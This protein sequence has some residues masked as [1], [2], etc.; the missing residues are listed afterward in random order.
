[1]NQPRSSSAMNPLVTLQVLINQTPLTLAKGAV[2][3]DALVTLQAKP[4][5]AV[6]INLQFVPKTSYHQTALHNGDCIDVITPVV[7]G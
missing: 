7:G 6:A 5:F 3:A 2:L 1:M 4:P